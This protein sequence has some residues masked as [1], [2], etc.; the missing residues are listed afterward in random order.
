VKAG[1]DAIDVC[2]RLRVRRD[3][4]RGVD[5]TRPG[6]VRGNRQPD[7]SLIAPQQVVEVP[8][9]AVN[10]LIGVERVG[11]AVHRRRSGHQLHQALGPDARDGARIAVRLRV[12]HRCDELA[13][14]GVCLRVLAHDRVEL[15]GRHRVGTAGQKSTAAAT[16]QASEHQGKHKPGG[17]RR[18]V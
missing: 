1:D 2:A 4:V 7:V 9:P 18:H 12:D 17:A 15:R 3:A 8:R 14:D 6:V 5:G 10:V 11:D 16:V 13:V